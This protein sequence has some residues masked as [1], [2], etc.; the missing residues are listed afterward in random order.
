MSKRPNSVT[1]E[2]L[3]LVSVPVVWAIDIGVGWVRRV[4][5]QPYLKRRKKAQA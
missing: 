2:A 3:L 5:T 4:I 1:T